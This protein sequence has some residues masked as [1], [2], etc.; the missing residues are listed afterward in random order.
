[1][2][3]RPTCGHKQ[4]GL[5]R[6]DSIDIRQFPHLPRCDR[7]SLGI[8]ARLARFHP[9]PANLSWSGTSLPSFPMMLAIVKVFPGS[10]SQSPLP[11]PDAKEFASW[12]HRPREGRGAAGMR[13]PVVAGNIP[14]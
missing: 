3:I 10:D 7:A 8:P 11:E 1:M 12:C 9:R 13:E 4:F 5:I 14:W 6:A 2:N